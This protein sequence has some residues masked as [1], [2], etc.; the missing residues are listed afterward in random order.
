MGPMDFIFLRTHNGPVTNVP[1]LVTHHSPT[2]F[3]WGYGGSGPADLALNILEFV[4]RDSEYD[5]P[6]MK[7]WDGKECFAASWFMHQT[8]KREIIANIPRDGSHKMTFLYVM[9]WIDLNMPQRS[10]L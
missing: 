6:K 4:L 9:N 7:T 3:E 10:I 1:Q 8:F 2:G 5:G